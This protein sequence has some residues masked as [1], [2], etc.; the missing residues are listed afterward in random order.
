MIRNLRFATAWSL[1]LFSAFFVAELVALVVDGVQDGARPAIIACAVLISAFLYGAA[2]LCAIIPAGLLATYLCGRAPAQELISLKWLSAR[3]WLW[4]ADPH[5]RGRFIARLAALALWFAAASLA[6]LAV[7]DEIVV[8]VQT[9]FFMAVLAFAASVGAFLATGLLWPAWSRTGT[10][11]AGLVRKPPAPAVVIAALVGMVALAA[12]IATAVL[13]RNVGS[14]VPWRAPLVSAGGLTLF[15]LFVFLR[16]RFPLGRIGR[17]IAGAAWALVFA[18]GLLTSAVLPRSFVGADILVASASGPLTP[19][20]RASMALFDIDRD[21]Y[22]VWFGQ[23]DCAP[24]NPAVHPGAVEI[25]G[26]GVDQDCNGRDG[27]LI[28]S[29]LARPGRHDYPATPTPRAMP[30]ILVTVDAFSAMHMSLYG[31]KRP[32]TPL[33]VERSRSAAVF[34]AAFS[35]GPSTR[36][37]FPSIMTSLHASQIARTPSRRPTSGWRGTQKTMA[38][39]FGKAGYETVAVA[40]D[41]YF[42]KKIRWLYRG[43]GT[44]DSSAVNKDERHK[45][46]EGVTTAAIGWLDKLAAKDRFFL[47]VHYTDAH[48]PHRLAPGVEPFPGGTESDIYD[49]EVRTVDKYVDKL[50]AAVAQRLGDRPY[51][52]ALTADHGQAFDPPHRKFHQDYDLSTAVTWIPMAFWSPYSGGRRIRQVASD[53]DVMPTLLN[54]V[55]LRTPQLAGN[56]LLPQIQG[57]RDDGRPIMQQ[58]FLPEYVAKDKEPLARVSVRKGDF[59]LHQMGWSGLQQLFDFRADPLERKDLSASRPDVVDDLTAYRDTILTWAYRAKFGKTK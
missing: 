13:W 3:G 43:F 14:L 46:G 7:L 28:K 54:M 4:S 18:A 32:T 27:A 30:V 55:G 44:V 5:V 42:A 6:A 19:I 21:G 29:P 52:V 51:V 59:V 24:L 48:Y 31:Y 23:G 22:S 40:P 26:D 57:R 11:L 8:A 49:A 53:I 2:A 20:S 1:R 56:S 50:L 37:S 47:W 35:E 41:D 58:F 39:V 45:S 17:R 15:A 33:L 38:D 34:D 10:L 25:P 16:R 9:P 12:A 36:L